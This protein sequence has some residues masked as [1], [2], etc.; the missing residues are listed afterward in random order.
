[1]DA[2]AGGKANNPL[3]P[4]LAD[5]GV[6]VLDGALATELE[7]RG[8]DLQ[9]RLWSAKLLAEDPDLIR[10]VHYDYFAAGADVATTASYQATFPGFAARGMDAAQAAACIRRSVDL[11]DAARQAFW[12]NPAQRVGRLRPLVAASIGPYGAYL[13]DG[14]EYRG[15]YG[16]TVAELMDFHRPRLALLAES[17]AD[18]LACETIPTLVEAEA[19]A[20]LLA[21]FPAATAWLSF[22]CGDEAHL[23][24][25]EPLA[26]AVA[27]ANECPQVV[28]VG[29]NCTA[30]RLIEPLL[31]SV[32]D[33]ARKPLLV[34]PNSGEGWDAVRRCWLPG[35]GVTD[36]GAAAR[37]WRAAG[38]RL[39][40]G[41]CR[42]APD[43]IRSIARALGR[44]G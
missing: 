3:A 5:H 6:M 18:L 12:A 44:D 32:R 35:A 43:D 24:H 25:G 31:A 20:A 11:A 17:A 38:A 36:F 29:V 27:L 37:M 14:S 40:G 33:L 13:A 10:Q 21:E 26:E 8:A 41:C 2:T 4:F 7:R 39:I 1:M 15:D 19:L 22:S 28:A 9:G 42:T 30:P 23:W 34:Y 16:L